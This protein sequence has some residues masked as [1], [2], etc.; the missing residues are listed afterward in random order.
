MK[1]TK[2]LNEEDWLKA[3]RNRITGSK[4]S[5]IVSRNA[6]TIAD[7]I[8]I[9]DKKGIEYDKKMK[10]EQLD[11]LLLEEDKMKLELSGDKKIGFYELLAER[12]TDFTTDEDS[13]D[14]GHRLEKIAI[15]EFEKQT[16]KKVDGSLLLWERD[17]NGSI[18]LSPDGMI[19]ETEAVEVKCLKS[20]IHLK[21]FLENRYPYEYREQVLQYFIVNEKLEKLYFVMYDDRLITKKL[22]YFEIKRKDISRDIE[23]YLFI[24]KIILDE[25]DSIVNKLTF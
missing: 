1:I 7:I 3:R 13:M 25:I 16:G 2:F 10:K 17:D 12:L 23:K 6:Y 9:L 14:R 18:A 20:A 11:A 19:G 8:S 22:F 15:E 21:S 24:Q 5:S 4:L